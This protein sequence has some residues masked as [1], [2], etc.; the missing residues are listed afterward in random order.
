MLNL[1]SKTTS[2][3]DQLNG[4]LGT[5]SKKLAH[6]VAI[7]MDPE[8]VVIHESYMDWAARVAIHSARS[9]IDQIHDRLANNERQAEYLKVLRI[10]KE[11]TDGITNT[12]LKRVIKG[13]F[14][15]RRIADILTQLQDAGRVYGVTS[16]G[17]K[18]GRPSFRWFVADKEEAG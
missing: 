17:P 4:I 11:S 6:I 5:F 9:T 7:G 16:T 15:N 14:D 10:I 13:E 12:N 3:A 1:F 18:G 2:P 8:D